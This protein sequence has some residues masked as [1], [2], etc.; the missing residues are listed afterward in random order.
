MLHVCLAPHVGGE[1]VL[2]VAMKAL[3][4]RLMKALLWL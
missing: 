2:H 1:H 3:L 4:S